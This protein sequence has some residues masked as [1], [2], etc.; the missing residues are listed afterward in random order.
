[1]SSNPREYPQRPIVGIGVVLCRPGHVLL[2]RR[3]RAPAVGQWSFPGGAQRLGETAEAA[4]RRELREETGLEAG[5]LQLVTYADSIHR[6]SNGRLRFHYTILDFCGAWQH[7]EPR[8][9]GDAADVAWAPV[10]ALERFAL[11]AEIGRV[12][13]LCRPLYEG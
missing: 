10:H 7:G 9:G 12:V 1:M 5:P 4:A 2:I 8:A 11:A 6:D 13:E 3:G